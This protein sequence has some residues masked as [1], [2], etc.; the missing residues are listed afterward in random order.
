[1]EELQ[2][3]IEDVLVELL[4]KTSLQLAGAEFIDEQ[5]QLEKSKNKC[6][7]I[8]PLLNDMPKDWEQ[9]ALGK[10]GLTKNFDVANVGKDESSK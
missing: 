5:R 10:T 9:R 7:G 3:R 1:M 8:Y 6:R 4:G 2:R